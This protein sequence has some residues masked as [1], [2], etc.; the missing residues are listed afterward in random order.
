MRETLS[1]YQSMD[2]NQLLWM[3]KQQVHLFINVITTAKNIPIE[4][5]KF[6]RLAV[7]GELSIFKP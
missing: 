5:V 7:A 2:Q 3:N 1:Q 6:P 4:E